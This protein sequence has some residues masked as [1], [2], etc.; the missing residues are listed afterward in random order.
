MNTRRLQGWSLIVSGVIELLSLVRSDSAYF[1]VLL[2][3]GTLLLILGVPAIESVQ[4]SGV[5][6]LIGI[7]LIE[8]GAIIALVLNMMSLGGSAVFSPVLPFTSALA[9][10]IGRVIV[11]WLTARKKAFAPWIGWA[12]SVEGLVNLAGGAFE[13]AAFTSI[14]GVIVPIVGAAALLGYGWGIVS[15]S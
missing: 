3:V 11:G 1:R 2:L 8:L 7:V 5:P 10:A 14:V 13:V 9:G 12:F 6:G 4:R 15:Q